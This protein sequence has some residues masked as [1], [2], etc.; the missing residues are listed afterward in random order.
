MSHQQASHQ[1]ASHQ[2]AS[3]QHVTVTGR[4]PL[5]AA[6]IAAA[7][8]AALHTEAQLTP[9]PGLVDRRGNR[10][11]PDM[12][13]AL[14]AVSAE[15]LRGPLRQCAEA[16][17]AIPLGV[18]LRARI[19]AIGRTGEQ[20]ML[21]VTGNVNT[22]RGALWT[23]GLLAAGA[24]G[25]DSIESAVN[26]AAHLARLPDPGL[27]PPADHALSHGQQTQLRYGATGAVGE[28]QAGFP[29]IMGCGLPALRAA[30]ARGDSAE[31]AALNALMAI[32]ASL[33]DT[34]VLHRGGPGAL[35]FVQRGAAQVLRSGGCAT[36]EG[37]GHLQRL[38]RDAGRRGLS[39]GGSA[40]LLAATLLLD[41]LPLREGL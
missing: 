14:L 1:Q 17:R 34:C 26:L 28:A 12:S 33:D 37:R 7:A 31:D 38:C 23:L 5:S 30:R 40:D 16:A 6:Q 19:G 39:A 11:H 32:M 3:H 4:P 20:R 2:Q 27:P 29:H 18:G 41:S 9:K 21:A 36:T 25:A 8:V 24:A 35:R 10:S 15:S 13:L 22:H